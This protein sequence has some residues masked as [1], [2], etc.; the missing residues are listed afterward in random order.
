MLSVAA[1]NDDVRAPGSLTPVGVPVVRNIDDR[2]TGIGVITKLDN[3]AGSTTVHANNATNKHR[4][5]IL[6]VLQFSFPRAST[7]VVE[8]SLAPI[9]PA[10]LDT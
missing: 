2:N 5:G 4:V 8:D 10:N 7:L 3:G 6:A 1:V 9:A